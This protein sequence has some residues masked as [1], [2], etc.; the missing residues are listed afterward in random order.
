MAKCSVNLN[1]TFRHLSEGTRSF[2][3]CCRIRLSHL[4]PF[5]F[6]IYWQKVSR[7]ENQSYR[8][9]QHDGCRHSKEIRCPLLCSHRFSLLTVTTHTKRW[10]VNRLYRS[11][12]LFLQKYLLNISVFKFLEIKNATTLWSCVSSGRVETE[13]YELKIWCLDNLS[14]KERNELE[15]N[16]QSDFYFEEINNEWRPK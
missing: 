15:V 5:K 9:Y 2:C 11:L 7:K 16:D 13:E 6:H 12:D 10:M 14:G 8:Q 4:N 1:S 3:F